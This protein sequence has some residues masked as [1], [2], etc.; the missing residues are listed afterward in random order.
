[1]APPPRLMMYTQ[2]SYGLGH[3]R[4]ATNIANAL[5]RRRSDVSILLVVD[6]PVAPFFELSEHI[7]FI[8][9][10]TVVKIDAGVFRAG[11]LLDS[12]EMVRGM[13]ENLLLEIVRRYAPD[14][15][16]VDHMPGGANRELEPALQ[17]VRAQGARL[18]LGLRDI[19]DRPEVT[20]AVWQRDGVYEAIRRYYDQVL[21]YGLAPLFP[22]AHH[23]GLPPHCE[24]RYCGYLCNM[25]PTKEPGRVR[26]R[27][28]AGDAPIV[29][30]MAGGGW[31][32]YQLQRVFLEA[33]RRLRRTRPLAGLVVTG[34]F[35]PAARRRTL[36]ER[37]RD[38]G[39][40]VHSTLGDAMTH[41]NAVDLVVSMAGYNTV[42]EI[43]RFRKRAVI[44]PRAGPSA[45]QR[46][47]AAL[48]AGQGLLGVLDPDQLSAAR[49]AE[50][51]AAGLDGPPPSGALPAPGL[52]GVDEVTRHLLDG[53]PAAPGGPASAGRRPP[54]EAV[55]EP[56]MPQVAVREGAAMP[57]ADALQDR[58]EAMRGLD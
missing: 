25:D 47:R 2:D 41:I 6:S 51:I 30:V 53:L 7:D 35:M 58:T 3:L 10:P 21:V 39:V 32:G 49:L 40:A 13:R 17:A 20:R 45:E 55:A 50:A 27:L 11:Q 37:A 16:L 44:V 28:A 29:S 19:I 8:K 38:L 4:R 5:V 12:Y 48:F 23:Y 22:T 24:V 31:D 36:R 33:V 1:M 18:V 54:A 43:L 9:L 15:I 14:L 46:M 42:S 34:P 56:S 52:A 57:A 26:S